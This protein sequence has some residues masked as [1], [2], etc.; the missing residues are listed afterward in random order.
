MNSVRSNNLS[1]KYQICT[2]SGW[3]DRDEQ[4]LVSDKNINMKHSTLKKRK[5]ILKINILSSDALRCLNV[6]KV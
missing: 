6:L 3:A 4:I 1:L 5:L 2:P